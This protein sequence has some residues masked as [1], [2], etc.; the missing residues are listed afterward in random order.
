MA[1]TSSGGCMRSA[2]RSSAST[3]PSASA[4]ATRS[5]GSGS[6]PSST[7]ASASPTGSSA[8]SG[9]LHAVYSRLAAALLD[10]MDALNAHAA[11]DRL[12]HVVDRQACDRDGG[13][14]L[15]L[16]AS[17]AG[18]LAGSAHDQARELVV[19][20][21]V[22]LDFGER[23]RVAER[24]QL[25]RLLRRHDAGD[26]CGTK[27]VALLG[28]AFEHE[29]ER[30]TRHQ[31]AA[32]GHRDAF[33]GS[34]RGHIHHAGLAALADVRESSCHYLAADIRAGLRASSALV[35]A[36]TSFCRIRLSPIRKE[37]GRASC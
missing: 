18:E 31:H 3:R 6:T 34:F 27:H 28:I 19:G 8:T 21:D 16:N 14:R 22:D 9:S 24:D 17:L 30:L 33:G 4:S 32:L 20:R 10:E 36:E 11:L 15:H 23:E 35:A 7:R 25:V 12:H 5:A 13:E 37:I 26:A 29:I 1:E 2:A